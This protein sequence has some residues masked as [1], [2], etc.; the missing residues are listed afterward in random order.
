M[1]SIHQPVAVD[2]DFPR[3][4]FQVFAGIVTY[5]A[6]VIVHVVHKDS[7]GDKNNSKTDQVD[8]S[9]WGC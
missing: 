6:K 7:Y 5:V 8:A 3:A 2:T 1:H 9:Q 4:K